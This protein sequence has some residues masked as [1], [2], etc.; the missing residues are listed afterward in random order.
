M[1]SIEASAGAQSGTSMIA[2]SSPIRPVEMPRPKSAVASGSPAAMT[3]PNVSS[4]TKAAIAMPTASEEISPV[5]ALAITLPPSSI[6][7]A[8]AVL[9][10][11]ELDEVLA[12]RGRDR[13]RELGQRHAQDADRPVARVV[14]LCGGRRVADALEAGGL[15][16]ERVDP[17]LDRG[18]VRLLGL[19][20][21]VDRVG[22]AL[23]EA[24]LQELGRGAGL[25]PRRRVVGRPVAGGAGPGERGDEGDDPGD[26]HGASAAVREVREPAE[27]AGGSLRLHGEGPPGDGGAPRGLRHER[28]TQQ[29]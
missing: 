14:G 16:G 19:P 11:R 8:V 26:E 27:A 13:A 23:G 15:P 3:E 25:R 6:A 17:L 29:L 5:C 4:R 7:D 20:D 18:R 24:L 28:L 10:L 21:D 22:A 2:A 12:G 1:P 9:V